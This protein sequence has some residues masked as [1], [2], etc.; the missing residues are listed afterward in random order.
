MSSKPSIVLVHGAWQTSASFHKIVPLL[1]LAGYETYTV[2]L[3]CSAQHT[4][5][6]IRPDIDTIRSRIWELVEGGKD[7]LVF[8]HSYGSVPGSEACKELDKESKRKQG[9]NGGITGLIFCCS[10]LLPEGSS[11][12]DML[13]GQ[14]LPWFRLSPDNLTVSPAAPRDLF[15]NDMEEQEARKWVDS[16]TSHSYATLFDKATYAAYRY[17]GSTY[18]FCTRDQA[19]PY[20]TQR[21]MVEGSKSQFRSETFYAGH[22]PFLTVPD[23]VVKAIRRAAGEIV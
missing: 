6:D 23:K 4:V 20:S 22:F 1:N 2:D 16:L 8:M 9:K 21:A 12:I 15:F 5:S 3:P 10:F 14:D 7:V 11:V 19:L 18:L 17:I 13:G